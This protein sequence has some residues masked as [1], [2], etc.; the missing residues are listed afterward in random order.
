MGQVQGLGDGDEGPRQSVLGVIPHFS[1]CGS[2]D[3][4]VLRE[5]A[6][7]LV[8]A[9]HAEVGRVW[10]TRFQAGARFRL[11]RYA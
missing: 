1:S 3:N 6:R 5:V 4:P 8:R 2:S 11:R 9:A 7:G 10:W